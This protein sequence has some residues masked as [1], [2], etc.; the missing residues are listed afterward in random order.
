MPIAVSTLRVNDALAAKDSDDGKFAA[1]RIEISGG[2]PAPP[3]CTRGRLQLREVKSPCLTGA[4]AGT[5]KTH[6]PCKGPSVNGYRGGAFFC[7]FFL[8]FAFCFECF[9]FGFLQQVTSTSTRV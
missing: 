2:H 4:A 8:L 5:L 9:L 1:K 6:G 7:F 3:S